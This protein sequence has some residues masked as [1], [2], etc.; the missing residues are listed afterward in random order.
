MK[1]T[2][3][4]G[5]LLVPLAAKAGVLPCSPLSTAYTFYSDFEVSEANNPGAA[6]CAAVAVAAGEV[7]TLPAAG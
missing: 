1:S 3:V 7:L 4:L 6:T 5:A 2:P